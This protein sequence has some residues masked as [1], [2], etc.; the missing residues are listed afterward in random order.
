MYDIVH[1]V[2]YGF[3]LFLS[4]LC[5]MAAAAFWDTPHGKTAN[6]NNNIATNGIASHVISYRHTHTAEY[7]VKGKQK[8]EMG[9]FPGS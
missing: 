1:N 7:K 6:T 9:L 2:H 3:I 8:Y 4:W 5:Y